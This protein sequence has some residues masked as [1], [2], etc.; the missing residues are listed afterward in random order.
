MTQEERI[1]SNL[2]LLGYKPEM[3]TFEDCFE[4]VLTDMMFLMQEIEIENKEF[5]KKQV[6]LYL[7][8][9]TN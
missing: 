5:F 4:Q 8:K 6:N 1:I 3:M 9:P 7:Q 2:K